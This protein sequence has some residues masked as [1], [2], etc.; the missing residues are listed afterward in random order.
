VLE[1]KWNFTLTRDAL[2]GKSKNSSGRP[3]GNPTESG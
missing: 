2:I 3:G 1:M